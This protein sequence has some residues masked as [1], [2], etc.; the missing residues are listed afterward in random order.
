MATPVFIKELNY[1]NAGTDTGKAVEVAGP[2][3]A[4]L[5]GWSSALY[6]GNGAAAYDTI[7]LSG[8]VPDQDGGFGALAFAAPGLQNGAADGIAL[9]DPAGSVA[10]FLSYE[11]AFTAAVGPADGLASAD[12]GVSETGL[13]RW[14]AHAASAKSVRLWVT[15]RRTSSRSCASARRAVRA[16]PRRRLCWLKALSACQR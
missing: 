15:T 1:D 10:Q 12:V 2:A 5:A 11:G 6:N 8:T 7:P 4:D 9:V 13:L 3:G 16:D 14:K